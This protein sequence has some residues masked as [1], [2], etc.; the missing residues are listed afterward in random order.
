MAAAGCGRLDRDAAG[1]APCVPSAPGARPS[2]FGDLG[3]CVTSKAVMAGAGTG[4]GG[5]SN[6]AVAPTLSTVLSRVKPCQAV[7]SLHVPSVPGCIPTT[8]PGGTRVLAQTTIPL[9]AL[10]LGK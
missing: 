5:V 10:F 7:P 8:A 4:E 2:T 3:D 6:T 1:R 9:F